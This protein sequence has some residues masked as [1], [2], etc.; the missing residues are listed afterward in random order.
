MSDPKRRVL[1]VAQLAPPSPLIAA[2][3]VAGLA[4]YL[5][6]EGLE[7]S[8][9]TSR[10]S[11][12]GDIE[13]ANAVAR[14]S[15]LMATPLNWRRSQFKALE[16]S[17]EGSYSKPSRLESV[18]VPDIAA[19]TW[20]P[21]AIATSRRLERE[22][23]WDC[24]ITTG[25]PHSVH[26][27]GLGLRRHG[28]PWIAEFRDGWTFDQPARAFPLR[29]QRQLDAA[30]ERRV[31]TGADALVGVTEPIAVDLSRRFARPAT[32]ITNAFD[33]DEVPAAVDSGLLDPDC[34]SVVH[35]GRMAYAGRSP[36]PLLEAVRILKREHPGVATRLE[37]VLAGP[38]SAEE[39]P[40][41]RAAD[42]ADTVR[43]IGTLD[44]PRTLELQHAAD[45]LLVLAE[46]SSRRVATG[47]LFEYLATDAPI[48]VLG[49]ETEAARIVAE[50]SAGFATSG[51]D[52]ALIASALQRLV[53]SHSGP[54]RDR[55]VVQQFSYPH[56]A[57]RY[58]E[59]LQD[60]VRQR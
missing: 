57:R 43:P 19:A 58:A 42:L 31:A 46:G 39:E 2:R 11:G 54:F 16:G 15:D 50:T 33:P 10:I 1:L 59:L 30:L 36:A 12:E 6:D 47:K 60:V 28:I 52:P 14:T 27:V 22:S 37:L 20:L 55:L 45:A 9:L 18:L 8:V 32:V 3:R 17:A 40:L 35:T 48:L 56:V 53:A 13:G 51:S 21:F 23:V 41:V 24:V 25:P 29:A 44:R 34:F 5:P 26:L 4:K 49:E 7:V 38:L